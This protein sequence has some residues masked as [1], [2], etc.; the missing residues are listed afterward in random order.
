MGADMTF[1]DAAFPCILSML[2]YYLLWTAMTQE[3]EGM[4]PKQ[5]RLVVIALL[6]PEAL[7]LV[8]WVAMAWIY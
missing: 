7:M 8:A 6:V 5:K 3:G 4:P 2:G 1:D